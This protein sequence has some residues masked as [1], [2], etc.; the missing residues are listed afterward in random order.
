MS[1]ELARLRT[2][3]DE[4]NVALDRSF[5]QRLEL[6]VSLRA[7]NARIATL[8]EYPPASCHGCGGRSD[9][10]D[11]SVGDLVQCEWCEP[12]RMLC[13]N[14]AHDFDEDEGSG[15]VLHG[16]GECAAK[17]DVRA[18]DAELARYKAALGERDAEI[19]RLLEE[20]RCIRAPTDFGGG[21]EPH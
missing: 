12:T 19:A 14:C 1:K 15:G 6:M 10:T 20:L 11:D 2:H 18:R 9:D 17:A 8:L 7:R 4:L 21:H 16:C 5:A 13:D 3:C